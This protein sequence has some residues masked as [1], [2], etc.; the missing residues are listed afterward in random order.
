MAF[1]SNFELKFS[2]L[3]DTRLQEK[4]PALY[5]NRV[6]FQLI[7]VNDTQDK[8][9]GVMAFIVDGQ[10]LYAPA[11][12]IKGQ[13]K[14]LELLYVKNKDMFVPLKD[15]WISFIQK[16]EMKLLGHGVDKQDV[17][18][19]KPNMIDLVLSP[20]EKISNEK[21]SLIDKET[22][23]NMFTKFA[24]MQTDLTT[25]LPKLGAEAFKVFVESMEK[26]ADFA[27]AV[28]NFYSPADLRKIAET[29]DLNAKSI[30]NKEDSKPSP[31]SP[32]EEAATDEF[33]EDANIKDS[34]AEAIAESKGTADVKVEEEIMVETPEEEIPA[35]STLV[36]EKLATAL[37]NMNEKSAAT[38]DMPEDLKSDTTKGSDTVEELV[39]VTDT[40]SPEADTLSDKQKEILM[41]DGIF[42]KDTRRSTTSVFNTEVNTTG[43][44]NPT[45]TGLNEVLLADGTAIPMLIIFPNKAVRNRSYSSDGDFCYRSRTSVG[46]DVE[47][48]L[49]DPNNSDIYYT[50]NVRE[51]LCKPAGRLPEE[52]Y[53]KMKNLKEFTKK[54]YVAMDGKHILVIDKKHNAICLE[55]PY[56]REKMVTSRDTL[57]VFTHDSDASIRFTGKDGKIAVTKNM[58]YIPNGTTYFKYEPCFPHRLGDVNTFIYHMRKTAKLASMKVYA[59]RNGY[60][61]T[62]DKEQEFNLNKKAALVNLVKKHG[63]QAS[64][65]KKMLK[66]AEWKGIPVSKRYFLKYADMYDLNAGDPRDNGGTADEAPR[67]TTYDNPAAEGLQVATDASSKGIKEV[68]DTSILASLAGTSHSMELMGTYIS[69]LIKAMD[70]V[71]RMLFLFYWHQEEFKDQYGSQEL[72][73]LEESLREIFDSVGDLVLFLKEKSVDFDSLF[74]GNRDD[75]SEDLGTE[76]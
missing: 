34:V 64:L 14:G 59:D 10:W 30:D 61:L 27:N 42:V 48:C 32:A 31:A 55:A 51:V 18:P 3:V 53:N 25:E 74:S 39:V 69:D 13:L 44:N 47:I 28:L 67:E 2:Q 19:T 65:A 17:K 22:V 62:T 43:F 38:T 50:K 70:R 60:A 58:A 37:L 23:N 72:I 29:I 26:N 45:S 66:E 54:N 1:D 11:F 41:R 68:M 73:E 12:F 33:G 71:G 40:T 46:P 8:G 35:R 9:V 15:S 5:P 52:L 24:E 16:G 49:I 75:M 36:K 4:V 76:E 56:M 7:D 63:I 6:G 57:P 20:H 21:D